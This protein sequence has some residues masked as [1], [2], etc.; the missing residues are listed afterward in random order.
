MKVA[1]T[2]GFICVA[3]C[4]HAVPPPPPSRV[5]LARG[6]DFIAIV[7]V[8]NV[9]DHVSADVA[10]NQGTRQS[11]IAVVNRTLKG[12][13]PRTIRLTFEGPPLRGSCHPANLSAGQFFV[14]LRRSGDGYV[15]TDAWY[16]Q[17]AVVTN[18]VLF[19][20]EYPIPLDTLVRQMDKTAGRR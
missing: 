15:R 5:N 6:S 10:W 13:A 17:G 1:V 12:S 2:I 7:T 11:A 18:H 4:V 20:Q 9:T 14:F 3:A 16:G 8:T 19:P